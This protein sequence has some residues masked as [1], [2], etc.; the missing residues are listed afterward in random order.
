[1]LIHNPNITVTDR[2]GMV[3]LFSVPLAPQRQISAISF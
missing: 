2:L 3:S 1:M